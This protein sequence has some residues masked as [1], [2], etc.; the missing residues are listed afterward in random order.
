MQQRENQLR[1]LIIE[2]MEAVAV[3]RAITTSNSNTTGT[4]THLQSGLTTNK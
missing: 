2:K 4:L 3:A 1:M